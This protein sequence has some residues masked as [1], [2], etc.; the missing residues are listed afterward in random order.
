LEAAEGNHQDALKS[1]ADA[2]ARAASLKLRPTLL[3]AYLGAASSYDALGDSA[4]ANEQR[5]AAQVMID[6]IA[7]LIPDDETRRAYLA[8]VSLQPEMQPVA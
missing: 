5:T 7:S 3:Q 1:F 6:A 8:R 4:R 2:Q